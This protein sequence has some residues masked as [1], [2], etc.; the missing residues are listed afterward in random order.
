MSMSQTRALILTV[1]ATLL[2]PACEPAGV[3]PFLSAQEFPPT[4]TLVAVKNGSD[5]KVSKLNPACSL[6]VGAKVHLIEVPAD[7]NSLGSYQ[8]REYN[9]KNCPDQ[10]FYVFM[11]LPDGQMLIDKGRSL[12][13]SA[14]PGAKNDA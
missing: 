5:I 7:E 2:L 14:T 10:F 3:T 13:S 12:A 9:N 1:A 11:P 6:S 4:V 8:V